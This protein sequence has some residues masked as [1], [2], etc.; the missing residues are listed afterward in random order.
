MKLK[1]G[2][3]AELGNSFKKLLDSSSIY[4]SMSYIETWL[5][6]EIK[7]GNLQTEDKGP[8]NKGFK[9]ISCIHKKKP[10][11]TLVQFIGNASLSVD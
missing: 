1:A 11:I 3:R 5:Y 10:V 6:K 8:R 4:V 7:P 9:I 2:N